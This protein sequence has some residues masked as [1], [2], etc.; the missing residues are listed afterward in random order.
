MSYVPKYVPYREALRLVAERVGLKEGQMNPLE[1]ACAEGLILPEV[2]DVYR[3]KWSQLKAGT[4]DR[5][6]FY[7]GPAATRPPLEEGGGGISLESEVRVLMADIDRIW[8]K[9]GTSDLSAVPPDDDDYAF[10]RMQIE[11][12]EHFKSTGRRPKKDELEKYF[13]DKKHLPGG[14]PITKRLATLMATL[15]RSPRAMKG[16]IKKLG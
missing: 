2:C 4:W 10:V 13:M 9:G 11:A 16:G 3:R 6:E 5:V 14:T 1:L 8:P 12:I 15:S 7:R